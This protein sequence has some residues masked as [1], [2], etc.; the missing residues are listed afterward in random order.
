MEMPSRSVTL[1]VDQSKPRGVVPLRKNTARSIPHRSELDR[2]FCHYW[3]QHGNWEEQ[4]AS[5]QNS[6]A[7]TSSQKK[8][9][10]EL[11]HTSM[12]AFDAVN[13]T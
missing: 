11:S 9:S 3:R 12:A 7:V 13:S 1:Q 10:G 4:T 5:V 8:F 6:K 2:N